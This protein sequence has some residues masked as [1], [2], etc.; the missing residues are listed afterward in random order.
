MDVKCEINHSESK[1]K[2]LKI[3]KSELRSNIFQNDF[4]K[5]ERDVQ[6]SLANLDKEIILRWQARGLN[7]HIY[8]L[9]LKPLL[10]QFT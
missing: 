7:E 6:L 1:Q 9:N 4:Q 3:N 5:Y 2:T 10:F 8:E